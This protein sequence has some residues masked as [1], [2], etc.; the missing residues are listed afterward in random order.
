MKSRI[1]DPVKHEYWEDRIQR[2]SVTRIMEMVGI[3]D[4]FHDEVAME[5]G[6]LVHRTIQQY[7]DVDDF[8]K[9]PK[10]EFNIDPALAG[11]LESYK[12][13]KENVGYEPIWCEKPLFSKLG[14]AGTPD[15]FGIIG[16]YY[17]LLDFKTGTIAW[18]VGVQLAGYLGLIMERENIHYA[19]RF[20]VGLKADGSYPTVKEFTDHADKVIF[21]NALN[22]V[23][24]RLRNNGGK[25]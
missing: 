14:Y 12:L 25:L 10:T 11:Y 3:S 9:E 1:F 16:S 5:L 23:N 18:F 13:W 19:R 22:I 8:T 7:E 20:A 4:H 21:Q 6:S 24:Y 2:P 17:A 15:G